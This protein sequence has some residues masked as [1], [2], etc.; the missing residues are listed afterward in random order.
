MG[1]A[2]NDSKRFALYK[3]CAIKL[4]YY[5]REP[6]PLCV[7]GTIRAIFPEPDGVYVGYKVA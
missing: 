4:K 3:A 2:Q 7:V 5:T 1:V 6:L